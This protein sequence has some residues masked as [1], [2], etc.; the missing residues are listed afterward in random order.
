[1]LVVVAIGCG[2]GSNGQ[3]QSE[4]NLRMVAVMYSQYL[5]A[6]GGE[7]PHDESEFRAYVDSLG[8]GVLHR[9]GLSDLDELFVSIRDGKQFAVKYQNGRW[10]LEGAIA[11][12]QVGV[13]GRRLVATELGG[14]SEMTEKQFATRL[15]KPM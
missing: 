9:A 10:P 11:Y 14:V 15:N 2:E 12:E 5:S 6:H 13:D 3:Q 1:M 7:A 8:P 4:S